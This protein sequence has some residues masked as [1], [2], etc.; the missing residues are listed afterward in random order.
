MANLQPMPA[1]VMPVAELSL[2][3]QHWDPSSFTLPKSWGEK[4][5]DLCDRLVGEC[6]AEMLGGIPVVAPTKSTALLPPRPDCVEVGP[7]R[8]IGGIRPQNFDVAYR[9]DGARFAF[10]S[11]TLNSRK[12]LSKNY[13]NMINDLGTEAATVHT[14]FPS[15]IVAFIVAVPEP[16]LA[17]HH[18][19]LTTALGRLSGRR[20]TTGDLHKAEAISLLVWD[21]TDG[22]VDGNWP[23]NDSPLRVERFSLQVELCYT[24]RFGGLPPHTGG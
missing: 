5:G 7:T 3:G 9:P 19:N 11:K 13:Q 15:A 23:P 10:D 20:S 2:I 18:N 24:D 17:T 22:S 12:S 6:L 4:V 16:C 1:V 8:V 21:P 14:R